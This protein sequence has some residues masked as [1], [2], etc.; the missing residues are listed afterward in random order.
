[1]Q[2]G[3]SQWAFLAGLRAIL[4]FCVVVTHTVIVTNDSVLV[5]WLGQTGYP[6]VF[7]FFMI[8]GYSIA[9]SIST[10][11]KGF[12]FRRFKR[13][14]PAYLVAIIFSF[15]VTLSGPL[16][17]PG[18]ETA[19]APSIRI[20]VGN[21]L[22]LQ[23]VIVPM[24][25][26]NGALWSLS[27]EWWCYMFAPLLNK[28]HFA[29]SMVATLVS[30]SAMMIYCLKTGTIGGALLPFGWNVPLLAWA[31]LTGYVYFRHRSKITF[32]L[33][34]FLPM[35]MFEVIV[36]LK[37]ASTVIAISAVGI[38][39]SESIQIKSKR[40]MR[41]LNFAGDVSYPLFLFHT[42]LLFYIAASGGIHNGDEIIAGVVGT[43]T[44]GYYGARRATDYVANGIFASGVARRFK[45]A[46]I[47]TFWGV[48]SRFVQFKF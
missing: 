41:A 27:I 20:V 40:A 14:Y 9:A 15:V 18:G 28:V 16:H 31:W 12:L 7:G 23:G 21:L 3:R 17:L 38:L 25:S 2:D 39:F 10:R 46:A 11:P 34:L 36:P 1:M 48:R 6:A 26:T 42:P 24:I 47:V 37:F 22:M 29:I 43:V 35:I 45:E 32:S 44:I 19:T 8:S 30:F 33:M 4:A 5:Q 13:I